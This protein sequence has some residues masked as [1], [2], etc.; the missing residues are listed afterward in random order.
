MDYMYYITQYSPILDDVGMFAL[1]NIQFEERVNEVYERMR[2]SDPNSKYIILV[3]YSNGNYMNKEE[4]RKACKQTIL[5]QMVS[6]KDIYNN[7]LKSL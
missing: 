3:I 2:L 4:L 6:A 1:T 7:I 5:K